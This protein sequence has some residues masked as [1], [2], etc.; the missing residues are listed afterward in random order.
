ML[1]CLTTSGNQTWCLEASVALEPLVEQVEPIQVDL[2]LGL[3]CTRHSKFNYKP[4][5][6]VRTAELAPLLLS[7]TC[8]MC[9]LRAI[10][11][12]CHVTRSLQGG[13]SYYKLKSAQSKPMAKT[14][15]RPGSDG[16]H[17]VSSVT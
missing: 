16:H 12:Y 3:W 6:R 11:V 4:R 14:W 5:L 2:V 7:A 17:S 13:G 10:C 15:V 9:A 8:R 1:L